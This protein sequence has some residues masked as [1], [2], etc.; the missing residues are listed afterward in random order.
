MNRLRKWWIGL[1]VA[2]K[3]RVRILLALL[4][5]AVVPSGIAL[6][7]TRDWPGLLLNIGSEMG[8]A[9]ITFILLDMILTSRDE[10][11]SRERKTEELRI[12]S[13]AEEGS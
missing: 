2:A 10:Q 13:S 12:H 9:L 3:W 11:E 1:S 7:I 4:V 8:G 6:S 5:G